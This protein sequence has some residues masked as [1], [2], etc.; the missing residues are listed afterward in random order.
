MSVSFFNLEYREQLSNTFLDVF[1]YSSAE[2][3]MSSTN[4]SSHVCVYIVWP[5]K[6]HQ[7]GVIGLNTDILKPGAG[8]STR[9]LLIIYCTCVL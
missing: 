7:R 3:L 9:Y 5:V 4:F 2:I 6:G 8:Y 1:L